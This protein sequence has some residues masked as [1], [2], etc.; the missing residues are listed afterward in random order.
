MKKV[1]SILLVLTMAIGLAAIP[2]FAI[3]PDGTSTR[4]FT[5]TDLVLRNV[6]TINLSVTVSGYYS[7]TD[8]T[9]ALTSINPT[10]SG[11]HAFRITCGT[12]ISGKTGILYLYDMGVLIASYQYTISNSGG[13]TEGALIQYPV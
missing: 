8:K 12:S 9:A 5:H 6:L 11:V 3:D 2:V 13:I 4:T 7:R 1:I 10:V